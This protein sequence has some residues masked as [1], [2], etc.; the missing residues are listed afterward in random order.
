MEEGKEG[1]KTS[2]ENSWEALKVGKYEVVEGLLYTR[3]HEWVKVVDQ[4]R[5]I[6]GITDYAGQLLH[7][8]V[9]VSLSAVNTEV[10]R[11]QSLGNVESVKAVSDIFSPLSGTIV[12]VNESLTVNP[13]HVNQSPYNEGWLVEIK[14]KDLQGERKQLLEAE[15]YTKFLEHP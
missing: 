12:K 2:A 1:L 7:E 13:E 9:Y 3:E 4:N 8:V 6:I 10:K 14:P 15:D 11:M 5:V